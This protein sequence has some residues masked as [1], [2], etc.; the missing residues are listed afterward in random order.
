MPGYIYH[1]IYLNSSRLDSSH[2]NTL[3]GISTIP[4]SSNL[5]I[6]HCFGGLK[7][8]NR[9]LPFMDEESKVRRKEETVPF[10]AVMAVPGF[11]PKHVTRGPLRCPTL[12]IKH[13]SGPPALPPR[14]LSPS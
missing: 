6:S 1:L 5:R 11:T 3:L 10:L 12:P 8:P 4:P 13:L 9:K 7:T 2:N 14:G